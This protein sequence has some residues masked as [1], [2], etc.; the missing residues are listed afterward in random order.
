VVDEALAMGGCEAIKERLRLQ[1]L[2]QQGGHAGRARRVVGRR[3][4][5]SAGHVRAGETSTPSIRC[6]I[7]YTSGSTGKPKGIQHSTAGYLL[8]AALT[9]KWTF[10]HKTSDV[11]WCTA[12]VGWVTGHTYFAYGPLA[13]GATEVMFRGRADLSRRRALLEDHPRTTR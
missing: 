8:W 11:F 10:D 2:R 7:L 4:E 9:M 5:G 1:A 3:G 6:F 12:D 13:V